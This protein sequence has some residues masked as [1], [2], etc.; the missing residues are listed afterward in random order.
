MKTQSIAPSTPAHT[1]SPLISVSA[2]LGGIVLLILLVAWI[3][4][5]FGFAGT[6]VVGKKT[7]QIRASVNLGPRERVVV[8][9]IEDA[10]LVLGVTASQITHLH[11]LPPAP[12]SGQPL[13][14]NNHA[15]FQNIMKKLLKRNGKA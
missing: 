15:D 8:V 2:T 9:D 12:E 6:S 10:R 7:L 1:D 5:R 4:R 3:A 14:N 11:T 13:P